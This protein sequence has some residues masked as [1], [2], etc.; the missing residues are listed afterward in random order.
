MSKYLFI[1]R[2]PVATTGYQAS[3]DEMKAMFA[4]WNAWKTKFK[5]NVVEVGDGLKNDGRI[6]KGGT[7]TD[8]PHVES[9]ELVGGYS[10]IQA[11][12]YDQAIEVARACPINEMPGA[13][14]EVRELMGF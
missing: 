3:P 7:V 6:L 8:G 10:I 11:T 13:Y 2:N 5:D 14:I 1:Y 4:R 12:G 9:K